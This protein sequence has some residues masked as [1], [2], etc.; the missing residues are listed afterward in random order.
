VARSVSV[1][2]I[3]A[4]AAEE[5]LPAAGSG[6]ARASLQRIQDS[7]REALTEIRQMLGLLRS[8]EA[9]ES[10]APQPGLADLGRLCE[11]MDAAGLPVELVVAGDTGDLPPGIDVSAYRIAQEALN[12]SLKHGARDARV[13]V[14]RDSSGLTID[15]RDRAG[16][17]ISARAGTPLSGGQGLIGIKERVRFFGGQFTA[18]PLEGGGF[19]VSARLPV[20]ETRVP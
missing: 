10:L 19:G 16:S 14:H 12:N 6:P 11:A 1:T 17:A 18:G 7:G 2:V 4:E 13:E 5:V 8:D 3:H 9:G 15:I 20:P